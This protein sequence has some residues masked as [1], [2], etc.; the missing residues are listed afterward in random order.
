M[1]VFAQLKVFKA[2]SLLVLRVALYIGGLFTALNLINGL[3]EELII[4]S[5]L[6]DLGDLLFVLISRNR[7]A[8]ELVGLFDPFELV[9]GV[10]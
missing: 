10:R 4:V 5:K 7:D 1:D 9:Y 8:L 3:S 2:A 6:A